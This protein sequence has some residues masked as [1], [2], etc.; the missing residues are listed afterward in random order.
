MSSD[1]LA[2]GGIRTA[3]DTQ[4]RP[5][6]DVE[7]QKVFEEMAAKG[8]EIA[9]AYLY[10]GC[11]CRAQLMIECMQP[12]G[13]DPGRAW[14]V[15]VG[16]KLS[17]PDPVSPRRK[18]TWENHV[19]PTVAVKGQ[20][21]GVLVIDPSLSKTGPMT[22]PEW[23][24]AAR[25][26]TIEISEV[27]LTQAQVL[28]L[29]TVRVLSGGQPLDALVFSLPRGQAPLPDVGGSGFRIAPDPQEGVSAFAHAQMQEFLK[30]QGQMRP[31]GH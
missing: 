5:L 20:P 23:A 15:S 8:N 29:Q 28:E 7:A 1:H 27:P 6:S 30:R 16:R 24:A 4:P 12:I 25:A 14:M 10:E 17:V 18:I 21:H 11:E 2:W 13:I 26:R 19:A 31:G 22:L 3:S 9:F